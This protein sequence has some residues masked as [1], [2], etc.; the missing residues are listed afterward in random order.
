MAKIIKTLS[1]LMDLGN[2][3][4]LKLSPFLIYKIWLTRMLWAGIMRF[5]L[6]LRVK[7][8]ELGHWIWLINSDLPRMKAIR[9]GYMLLDGAK[10]FMILRLFIPRIWQ[11][12]RYLLGMMDFKQGCKKSLFILNLLQKMSPWIWDK[13][14]RLNVQSED[15]LIHQVIGRIC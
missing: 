2:S 13:L 11:R 4:L 8:W 14:M 9:V 3:E 15:G 10:N 7:N 1:L 5:K 12:V 6:G